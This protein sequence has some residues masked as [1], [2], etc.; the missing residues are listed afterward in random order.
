MLNVAFS[1]FSLQLFVQIVVQSVNYMYGSVHLVTSGLHQHMRIY[2]YTIFPFQ[3]CLA[4][5]L[6][7][8]YLSSKI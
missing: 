4:V 6:V 2:I 3:L 5:K 8:S 1:D 7:E